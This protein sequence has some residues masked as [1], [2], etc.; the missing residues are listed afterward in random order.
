[1]TDMNCKLRYFLFAIVALISMTSLH[2]QDFSSYHKG[3][4]ECLEAELDGS[5]TLRVTGAGK[6]R[7]DAEE[8][9][10]KNA[11]YEI[12]FKGIVGSVSGKITKPLVTEVNARERYE[13]YFDQFFADGGEYKNFVSKADAKRSSK[14][15]TK[16]KYENTCRLTVR[17]LRSDLKAHLK[18]DGIIKK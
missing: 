17:V 6:N 13:E 12:I 1:M 18:K 3:N 14:E 15:K 11:V 4:I 8:Q 2:A 7:S 16:K 9:A 10:K 5:L